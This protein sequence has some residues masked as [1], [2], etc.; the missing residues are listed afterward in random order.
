MDGRSFT[1]TSP[2]KLPAIITSGKVRKPYGIANP[3]AVLPATVCVNCLWDTGAVISMLSN[4]IIDKLGLIPVSKCTTYHAHGS[5]EAYIYYV[6]LILPNGIEVSKLKV[7]GG[8][9]PD[10]DMLV[11]MDVIALCDI[12]ITHPDGGTM[13]SFRIANGEHIDFSE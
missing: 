5:T 6:N 2:H 8:A 10:T 13:F 4:H 7:I 12:A 11:G 9:L 1:I 3:P